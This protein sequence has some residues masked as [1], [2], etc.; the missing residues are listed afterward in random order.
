LLISYS[1]GG[2]EAWLATVD[3]GEIRKVLE[4]VERLSRDE[5]DEAPSR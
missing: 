2:D 1:V 4:D 5:S 3:A